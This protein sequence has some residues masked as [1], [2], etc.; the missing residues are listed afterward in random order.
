MSSTLETFQPDRS[1]LNDLA[2]ENMSLTLVA[3]DT[4]QLDTFPLKDSA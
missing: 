2:H 4:S 3:V 1:W